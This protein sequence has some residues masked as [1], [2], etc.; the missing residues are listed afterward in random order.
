MSDS[1][2]NG[3]SE[4]SSSTSRRRGELAVDIAN[5]GEVAQRGEVAKHGG[6]V[7]P[8]S[9]AT[10]ISSS[11]PISPDSHAEGRPTVVPRLMPGT[12]VGQFELL[13]CVGGGGMGRVYRA[14]DT[15][16]DRIVAL[17]VLSPE[18]AADTETLLRFRNEAKSAARLNHDNIVQVYH[19]GEDQ[20]LPFIVF[21]FIEGVHLRSLVEQKGVL[22]LAE[23]ISYTFQVAEA[24]AH[25]QSHNIVHRDIKPSNV[26]ITPGGQAKLIDMGLAR[27]QRV[28]P[29]ANDL[30]ASGVTLGTFDYISPEQARDPRNADSRSDIYSL[31]CTLFFVLTGRPPFPAGTVLQKLL[32]HQGDEPPDVREFRPEMPEQVSRL[33]RKMMAKDP[34]QRYQDPH[35]LMQALA[36]LAEQVGLRPVGPGRTVWVAPAEPTVSLVERHLPWAVPVGV[37]V[38]VVLLLH[39]FWSAAARQASLLS[40]A[41]NTATNEPVRPEDYP[42]AVPGG[43]SENGASKVAVQPSDRAQDRPPAAPDTTPEK[44]T[45]PFSKTESTP[46][47]TVA[48]ETSN[49]VAPEGGADA[50]TP[51]M[52]NATAPSVPDGP[53]APPGTPNAAAAKL[54]T[55]PGSDGE[56]GK[57]AD[58][59]RGTPS[60]S[61]PPRSESATPTAPAESAPAGAG[62]LVVDGVG[63]KENCF[64]TLAAA[65]SAAANNSVIKLCFNGRQAE[66]PISLGNVK[67]TV[68]AGE[69]FQPVVVFRPSEVDPIQYPRSMITLNGTRLI[70][71]NV[72]FEME[73]PRGIAA[74]CWTLFDVGQAETAHLEQCSLTIRNASD[75]QAAYH[76]QVAFFLA[77]EAPSAAALLGSE[78]A[79][80]TKPAEISLA[81]CIARGEAVF[82]RVEGL[83]AVDLNWDNGLLATAER[84]LVVETAGSLPLSGPPHRI[85]LKHLTA[86]VRGGLCLTSGQPSAVQFNCADSILI[87]SPSSP[88]IEQIGSAPTEQFRQRLSWT[89]DRNFYVGVTN[90]WS[91]KSTGAEASAE[92][93]TL[94]AWRSHWGPD[95]NNVS[96]SVQWKQLPPAERAVS[97]HLPVDYSLDDVSPQNPP[98]K[99]AH[100]GRDAGLDAS[101][102]PKVAKNDER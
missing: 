83:R 41:W 16:L 101:R 28:E 102:L 12:R 61:M 25:A 64:A 2:S 45:E 84:L 73:I 53:A 59:E 80:G 7:S 49:R 23:A 4:R 26:V 65:A 78:P 79:V 75:Q 40:T 39:F 54:P 30:T 67:L 20:G 57:T 95:E 77:K 33:V 47:G 88:L 36:L 69:G 62:E 11:P 89:G 82:L 18:Q 27:L 1:A 87:A 70:V 22:S 100:D 60:G 35:K 8:E 72:A 66:R 37:L 43:T 24:L 99:A 81:D 21:E 17:K 74:D 46:S 93:M 34:R 3:Q 52:P 63:Q 56:A 55:A 76:Q 15:G 14:L 58:T 68:R 19:I 97:A 32:Q 13:E 85:T 38:A 98:R 94:D 91:I 5:R 48:P 51:A 6:P 31:G 29:Q 10:V 50:R 44:P 96:T 86:A 42:E 9:Q 92:S 71:L 90:F